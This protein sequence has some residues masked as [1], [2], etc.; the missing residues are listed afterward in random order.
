MRVVV[1]VHYDFA[2]SL[3][4][5][6]HRVMERLALDLDATGV[7]LAW[8]PLDLAQL[9]GYPRGA[10]IP[11][12]RRANAARV[13]RDLGVPLDV[14]VVWRDSRA[15]NAAALLA[16]EAGCDARFREAAWCALY[17]GRDDA[18][19]EAVAA[20]S[21]VALDRDALAAAISRVAA[22]TETA[23][24]AEVAGVPTFV[25]DRWPLCGI[26]SEAT[27]R[28]LL[29]RFAKRSAGAH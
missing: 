9:L 23:R 15:W 18:S 8:T 26:Q 11:E 5:V 3:C 21:G 22:L 17:E 2:S 6:A 12:E 19:V 1:P 24:E 7:A 10:P 25:L 27:M 20:A 29:F 4:Y 28:A 16:A 14:P 13:A